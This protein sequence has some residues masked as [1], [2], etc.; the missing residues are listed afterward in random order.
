MFWLYNSICHLVDVG[1]GGEHFKA[2]FWERVRG[3]GKLGMYLSSSVLL[4]FRCGCVKLCS[5]VS[6][7]ILSTAVKSNL[8]L[9]SSC[10]IQLVFGELSDSEDI[11]SPL[12]A[13]HHKFLSDCAITSW[14]R[15]HFQQSKTEI[16]EYL[17]AVKGWTLPEKELRKHPEI[18]GHMKP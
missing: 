6:G 9:I 1:G 16:N 15:P 8:V 5:D 7:C 18:G 17:D 10:L 14:P 12:S 13:S 4:Y 2:F 11:C 3:V